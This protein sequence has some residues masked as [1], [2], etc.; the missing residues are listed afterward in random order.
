VSH[1]NKDDELLASIRQ[2]LHEQELDADTRQALS[3]IRQQALKQQHKPALP[4]SWAWGGGLAMAA[5]VGAL[6]L[7]LWTSSPQPVDNSAQLFADLELLSSDED[8][9]LYEDLDF[10]VWLDEEHETS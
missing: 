8:M 4:R 2:Q 1:D 3:R 6:S 9:Q 7:S 5:G 10:L